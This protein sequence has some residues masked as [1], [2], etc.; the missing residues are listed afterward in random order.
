MLL[1]IRTTGHFASGLFLRKAGCDRHADSNEIV[2]DLCVDQATFDDCVDG[3]IDGLAD[4]GQQDQKQEF[5]GQ[6]IKRVENLMHHLLPRRFLPLS[7]KEAETE[8]LTY[9]QHS[10]PGIEE[11][12]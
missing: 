1:T 12:A 7:L 2:A 10:L 11:E 3:R 4:A 6:M 9:Q 5:W 8:F